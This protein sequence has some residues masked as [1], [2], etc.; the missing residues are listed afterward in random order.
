MCCMLKK[1][2]EQP[3]THDWLA[4]TMA[5]L[6]SN[7]LKQGCRLIKD[8]LVDMQGVGQRARTS[9]VDQGFYWPI[10]QIMHKLRQI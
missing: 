3:Q 4:M 2:A 5:Q 6:I 10:T 9:A 1:K 7:S 8:S